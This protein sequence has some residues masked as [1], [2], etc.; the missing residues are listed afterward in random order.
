MRVRRVDDCPACGQH[1]S[2]V[3][4]SA[5]ETARQGFLALSE[6]KYGG[7]MDS[8]LKELD[9]TVVRCAVCGHHW[10]REQPDEE[11]L[12][13][14]YRTARP[15]NPELSSPGADP[16]GYAPRMLAE[17]KRLRRL[18]ARHCDE[19][20][21]A[22]L[23]Y[24]AGFGRWSRAASNA[25]FAVTAYE[26][27][28]ERGGYSAS[29]VSAIRERRELDG[30]LFDAIN[31]EQVLE[32]VPDPLA[33][34]QSIK[35][36]CQAHTIVRITVPN[37]ARPPEGSTIWRDWPFDGRRTHTMAPFEHLH[38]F[39]PRSV[40]LLA[41][42]AGFAPMSSW[43]LWPDHAPYVARRLFAAMTTILS[44]TKL[45]VVPASTVAG[46]PQ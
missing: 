33:L 12:A 34:L 30:R 46:R 5:N 2:E 6:K 26:P 43:S 8:W 14:L 11:A 39:T 36:L 41:V 28:A 31:V 25:G 37:I 40:E 29:S 22:L 18:V 10:Y 9:L 42:R 13:L 27:S 16:L 23:D 1:G 24:G 32:H 38:G 17:M 3:I 21:P 35:R 7:L 4:A 44:Q 45:F 19:R 20:N 15:L